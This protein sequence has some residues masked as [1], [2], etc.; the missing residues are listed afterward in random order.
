MTGCCTAH[1]PE[2]RRFKFNGAGDHQ[3][4]AGFHR[5]SGIRYRVSGIR[6]QVSGFG[7][8]VSAFAGKT[9]KVRVLIIKIVQKVSN[10]IFNSF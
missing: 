1:R 6:F 5:V 9:R 7:F 10:T 2:D 3:E 8:R 4:F